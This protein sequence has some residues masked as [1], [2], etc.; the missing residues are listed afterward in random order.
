M[1]I[2]NWF[3]NVA[4]F[5]EEEEEEGVCGRFSTEVGIVLEENRR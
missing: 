4:Q 2:I 1:Y 3:P 5:N